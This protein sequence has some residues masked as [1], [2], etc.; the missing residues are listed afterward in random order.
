MFASG[1]ILLDDLLFLKGWLITCFGDA[2]LPPQKTLA[3]PLLVFI[4]VFGLITLSMRC[5]FLPF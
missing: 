4:K 2:K 5:L 1:K 3:E